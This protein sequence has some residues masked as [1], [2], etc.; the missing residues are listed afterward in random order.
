MS[1]VIEV[2]SRVLLSSEQR[3]DMLSFMSTLGEVKTISRVM[4]DFSGKDR[5]RTVVLR[6]N[7]GTLE[8]VAKTG[9]LSDVVRHEAQLWL[10]SSVSLE[11]A[12]HWLAIMGYTEAMVSLRKMFVVRTKEL[13]YSLRDVLA[14]DL[15]RAST[16]LEVEV[17]NVKNGTEQAAVAKVNNALRVHGLIPLSAKEWEGWV[18]RTYDEV[19]QPFKYSPEAVKA[20]STSLDRMN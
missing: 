15:R 2:E 1:D 20:L 3:D 8:L 7:N 14:Q 16:L 19:D 13:E 9:K 11:N 12:L 17:L 5:S 6:V 18:K 10:S 4:V